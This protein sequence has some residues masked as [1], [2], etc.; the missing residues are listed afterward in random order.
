ML[1]EGFFHFSW[2]EWLESG[3]YMSGTRH[4]YDI[5]I[6]L[7][8]ELLKSYQ[9]WHEISVRRIFAIVTLFFQKHLTEMRVYFVAAIFILCCECLEC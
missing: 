5:K 4:I 6:A 8:H 7:R 3:R 9:H 1:N 2:K